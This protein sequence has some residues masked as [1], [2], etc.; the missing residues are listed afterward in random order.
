MRS[1]GDL[2]KNELVVADD[3]SIPAEQLRR[4]G[5]LPG[6]HVRVVESGS[7]N[8]SASLA[9]SLPDLPDLSWQD[10]ERASALAGQDSAP[11]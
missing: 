5:V 11:A 8:K 10:F 6:A 1:L 2:S 7:G 9:G 3:G 4:L